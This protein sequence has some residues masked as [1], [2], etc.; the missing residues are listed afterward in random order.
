MRSRFVIG[1][2]LGVV[3]PVVLAMVFL[4]V[5]AGAAPLP[6][7]TLV[8]DRILDPTATARSNFSGSPN[9]GTYAQDT[10]LTHAGYQYVAWYQE[11]GV[12]AV[13]RRQLPTGTWQSIELDFDLLEDDSHNNISM[14]VSPSD[15][16]LHIAFGQHVAPTW[17]TR[18]DAGVASDPAS[19]DWSYELFDPSRPQFPGAAGIPSTMTYPTFET[20]QGRLLMTYREGSPSGGTQVLMRYDDNAAGTWSY[21]GAFSGSAG[22]WRG[23]AGVSTSRNGYLHGFE[24]DPTTGDLEISWTYR[25]GPGS[26]G[27]LSH[28]LMFATSPD[29]GMTWY[30]NKGVVVGRTGTDDLITVDDPTVVVPIPVDVQLVNSEAATVDNRGRTHVITSQVPPGV[31]AERGPCASRATYARP[32]HHWR[33]TDGVWRSMEIPVPQYGFGRSNIVM[34]KHDTAYVVLPNADIISATASSAWTD[35]RL[36]HQVPMQI[37][38]EAMV[39]RQRLAQDGILSVAYQEASSVQTLNA[40]T[41]AAFRVADFR[42]QPGQREQARD[43]VPVAAPVPYDGP[44]I[45]P[46]GAT[47]S[48]QKGS[49]YSAEKAFDGDL[50]TRWVSAG[51]DPGDGPT[52]DRPEVLTYSFGES[53]PIS[54]VSVLPGSDY[55]PRT[56]TIEA[57]VDG[58]WV[59]LKEVE[60]GPSGGTHEVPPTTVDALRL[61]ITS[62][63]DPSLPGHTQK[64]AAR[65]GR[66]HVSRVAA[67]GGPGGR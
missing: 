15:G 1:R 63:Y 62:S 8:Q 43:T 49:Q 13:S 14:G 9:S 67:R 23:P 17:Y 27:C 45:Q 5:T 52:P 56:F 44:P 39:D 31:R 54:E 22:S 65:G 38:K 35:W 32:F 33:D 18:S 21:E 60:Q 46:V 7:A 20:V 11:D 2:G 66:H 53:V 55:G 26:G 47:A 19:V 16:R 10:V 58:G 30:N 25:E 28:D 48:S 57:R 29:L 59:V 64:R 41:P 42:V 6:H 61:A 3:L 34:D 4:P 51:T 36:V 24:A 37:N 40:Q 50:T 12:A